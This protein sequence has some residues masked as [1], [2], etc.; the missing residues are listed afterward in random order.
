MWWPKSSSGQ[1]LKAESHGASVASST[2][3]WLLQGLGQKGVGESLRTL[4]LIPL[5]PEAW[6]MLLFLSTC[7]VSVEEGMLFS[8]REKV[9]K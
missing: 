2:A 4:V 5:L 6:T 3:L 9:K 8:L 1:G 7:Q